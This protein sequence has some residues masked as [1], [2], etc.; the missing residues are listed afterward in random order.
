MLALK[1]AEVDVSHV[2]HPSDVIRF[3]RFISQVY[4]SDSIREYI[5]RIVRGTRDS[6]PSSFAV[7][8]EMVLQG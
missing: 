1:L 7:V 4:V 8:K 6:E 5:I 2:I 3:R